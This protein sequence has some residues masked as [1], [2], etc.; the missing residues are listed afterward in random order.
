[1]DPRVEGFLRRPAY[2][3]TLVLIAIMAI[4][5]VG[6]YI[7]V[8]QGQLEQVANLESR[9]GSV[10]TRLAEKQRIAANL[11]KFRAEYE[12]LQAQ[13]NDALSEL[14]DKKEISKLLR[15][16][17]DLARNQ[18][19]DVLQFKPA[20]EVIKGFYAEVPVNLK[21]RG[22]YHDIAMFFDAVGRLPR[23][24]N[25][26]QL[27]MGQPSVKAG[28][29]TLSVDCRTTTF[30]FVDSQGSSNQKSAGRK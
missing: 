18:G 27:R 23:I 13:L 15:N 26:D 17:S 14:P 30:R 8:Y 28:R 11:P 2:Q 20:G 29:T 1:M 3:R 7:L 10:H 12:R 6:F 21:L 19:L 16:I 5:V 22:P 25:I 9:L 24:V 4:V